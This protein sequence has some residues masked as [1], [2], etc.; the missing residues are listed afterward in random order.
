MLVAR[1]SPNAAYFLFQVYISVSWLCVIVLGAPAFPEPS[2]VAFLLEPFHRCWL[3]KASTPIP[4]AIPTR[5][6]P[7]YTIF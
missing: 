2:Y 1:A 3:F 6:I 7:V 5:W 4:I